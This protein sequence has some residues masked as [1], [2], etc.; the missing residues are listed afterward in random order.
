MEELRREVLG[1]LLQA[2]IFLVGLCLSLGLGIMLGAHT[3]GPGGLLLCTL[4]SGAGLLGAAVVSQMAPRRFRAG[5]ESAERPATWDTAP[6]ARR[7]PPTN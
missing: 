6:P 4:L 5:C 3:D 7:P 1:V 2:V